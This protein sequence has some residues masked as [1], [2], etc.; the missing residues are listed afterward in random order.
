MTLGKG[1]QKNLKKLT[2]VSFAFT[3]TYT[4]CSWF[5]YFCIYGLKCSKAK[6]DGCGIGIGMD[7]SVKAPRLRAL[8]CGANKYCF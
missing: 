7:I 1:A 2:S 4:P 3:H 5:R 8:L 6:V